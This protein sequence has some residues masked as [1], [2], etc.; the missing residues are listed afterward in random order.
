MIAFLH[1]TKANIDRFDTL[2]KQN[3]PS[4]QVKHFVNEELLKDALSHGKTNTELFNL[5]IDR[6]KKEAPSLIICTCST[7]GE[8]C[9]NHSDI[10]R[11]D[12]PIAKF[13]VQNYDRIGLA[14]TANST[15]KV[16]QDLLIRMAA[17]SNKQIEIIACDCSEF[18]KY[19]ENGSILEYEKRIAEKVKSLAHK[20]DVMFLC[21]A[22]MEGAISHLQEFEKAVLSSPEYGIKTLL[23]DLL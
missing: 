14:Y 23:K 19:F 4:I 16:S 10:S 11:I 8:E 12:E 21:Q 13:I 22:S 5:E 7:Y 6:I 3:N 20:I 1:T 9:D 18:W 15:K 17:S 2:V